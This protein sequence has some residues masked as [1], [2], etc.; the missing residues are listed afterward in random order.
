MNTRHTQKGFTL[1]ELLVVITILGILAAIL[2]PVFLKMR[3]RAHVT[4]CASNLHQLG[5]AIQMYQQDWNGE[6]P[7]SGPVVSSVPGQCENMDFY[8]PYDRDPETYHCPNDD[9]SVVKENGCTWFYVYRNSLFLPD[10]LKLSD[11]KIKPAPESVLMYCQRHQVAGS[12]VLGVYTALRENGAVSI[13]PVKKIIFWA[14]RSGQW[15]PV[16]GLP[17]DGSVAYEVFPSEVWPPQFEK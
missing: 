12:P 14:Y 8:K 4:T 15:M 16:G 6:R 7:I 9:L 10:R 13:V 17:S 5:L 3:E 1:I 11:N 2:F